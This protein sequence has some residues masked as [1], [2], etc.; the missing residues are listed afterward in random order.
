MTFDGALGTF[1][2]FRCQP[3]ACGPSAA[4]PGDVHLDSD[5]SEEWT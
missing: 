3:V 1:R 2:R 4:V 5:E